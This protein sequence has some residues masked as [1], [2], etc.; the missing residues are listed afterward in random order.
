MVAV[1]SMD[2]A[3]LT[4]RFITVHLHLMGISDDTGPQG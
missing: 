1:P 3:A 2:W 4:S